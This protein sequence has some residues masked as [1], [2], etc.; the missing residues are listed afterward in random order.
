[1]AIQFRFILEG[2]P[3]HIK[4]ADCPAVRELAARCPF[5][6]EF[7]RRGGHE[8]YTRMD[9]GL[10]L[11]G[12]EERSVFRRNDL[13]YFDGWHALAFLFR[14]VDLS[15]H[16]VQYLGRFE[17]DLAARLESAGETVP[18]RIELDE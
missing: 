3:F 12:C 14:D 1:M 7:Q 6:A 18:M 11:E 17:E 13:S 10:P 2:E 16:T 8:Y 4:M 15:P 9:K 5:T